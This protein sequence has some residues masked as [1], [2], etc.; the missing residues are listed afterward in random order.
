MNEEGKFWLSGLTGVNKLNDIDK[1]DSPKSNK[2]PED[3]STF[4]EEN[5]EFQKLGALN[6]YLGKE[7]IPQ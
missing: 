1:V 3:I 4:L 2:Q 7:E 5:S 6:Q